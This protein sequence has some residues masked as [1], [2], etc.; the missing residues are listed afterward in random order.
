MAD[1]K[2]EVAIVEIRVPTSKEHEGGTGEILRVHLE[3]ILRRKLV[4]GIDRRFDWSTVSVN[5]VEP[6]L[7]VTPKSWR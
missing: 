1:L 5:V 7:N 2:Q 6:E 3:E 4:W